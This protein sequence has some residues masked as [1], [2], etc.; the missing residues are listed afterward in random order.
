VGDEFIECDTC[1]SAFGLGV[2]QMPT[3]AALGAE[4]LTATREAVTWLLRAG[5]EPGPAAASVAMD[6]LARAAGSPWSEQ[7]LRSDLAGLDVTGLAGRLASL[8]PALNEHGKETF[9]AGCARVAAA[10]GPLTDDRQRMLHQIAASLGM[11][12][13]HAMGVIVQA[14]DANRLG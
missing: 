1:K 6:V 13:A 3:T 8:A 7:A 11:S 14:T 10:G 12:Q 9:L 5:G 2:L 4:L